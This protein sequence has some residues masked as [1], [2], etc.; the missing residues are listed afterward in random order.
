MGAAGRRLAARPVRIEAAANVML[1]A[2]ERLA[3]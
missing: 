2:V 3:A 1:H